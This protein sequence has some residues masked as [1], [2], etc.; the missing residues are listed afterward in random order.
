MLAVIFWL[1]VWYFI[2]KWRI[3]LDH[4]EI[5]VGWICLST[6]A[7]PS[8]TTTE[9]C[10]VSADC[11]AVNTIIASASDLACL[12]VIPLADKCGGFKASCNLC[13]LARLL[14]KASCEWFPF[15]VAANEKREPMPQYI[16]ININVLT[17][18]SNCVSWAA[19]INSFVLTFKLHSCEYLSCA[20]FWSYFS[21]GIGLITVDCGICDDTSG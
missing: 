16:R 13:L 9:L 10:V 12:T 5:I 18:Y 6:W 20:R 2:E 11:K 19:E 14:K 21:D 7:S 3:Y 17:P 1:Y 4:Q 15:L 8:S